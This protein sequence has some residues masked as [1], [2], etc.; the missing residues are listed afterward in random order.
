MPH[1]IHHTVVVSVV[2]YPLVED[3][4]VR[5]HERSAPQPLVSR[6]GFGEGGGGAGEAGSAAE[7]GSA[8]G[9]TIGGCGSGSNSGCV[10]G[11]PTENESGP[12]M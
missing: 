2:A 5:H 7:G 11:C 12:P 9:E 3:P 1:R 10:I 8:G 4:S 6:T